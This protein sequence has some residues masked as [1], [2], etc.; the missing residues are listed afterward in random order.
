MSTKQQEI[1]DSEGNN[2]VKLWVIQVHLQKKDLMTMLDLY[3]YYKKCFVQFLKIYIFKF[4]EI[5]FF[6]KN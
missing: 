5:V 6:L 4:Q 2:S 1:N 3:I